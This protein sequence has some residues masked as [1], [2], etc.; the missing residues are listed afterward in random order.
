[1][2]RQVSTAETLGQ[3]CG[4]SH[5]V[6]S[7]LRLALSRSWVLHRRENG[8]ELHKFMAGRWENYPWF[9]SSWFVFSNEHP[10]SIEP[11]A[12][13]PAPCDLEISHETPK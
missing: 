5:M 2:K 12:F 10:P 8:F 9:V 13:K 6:V 1:M 11:T 7:S 3:F 4:L